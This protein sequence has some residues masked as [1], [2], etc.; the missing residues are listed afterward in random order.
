MP[1]SFNIIT[2]SRLSNYGMNSISLDLIFKVDSENSYLARK[3]T[4]RSQSVLIF[5]ISLQVTLESG[6]VP[7]Q[8]SMPIK[9]QTT[10]KCQEQI[11]FHI[12][13]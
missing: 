9:L 1:L 2:E 10:S 4:S 8:V 12:L 5:P 7:R 11:I 6:C 13:S 3:P